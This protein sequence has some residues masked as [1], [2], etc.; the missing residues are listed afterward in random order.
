MTQSPAALETEPLEKGRGL[1]WAVLVAVLAAYGCLQLSGLGSPLFWQDEGETAMFGQR[2]L[3]F[4]YP[5]VHS[6]GNVVYGIG[7]PLAEGVDAD[8]DAYLGSFWGQYYF[9]A[10]GVSMGEGAVDPYTRTA[11][12]RLPFVFSGLLGLFLLWWSVQPGFAGRKGAGLESAI[13]FG[14][15]LC[16]SISLMLHIREVRYYGP[17]LALLAGGV[18]LHL[19]NGL[20]G[21]RIMPIRLAC[22]LVL[23]LVLFNFFFPAALALAAWWALESILLTTKN[24]SSIRSRLQSLWPLACVL[25]FF[26][27]IAFGL[28]QAFGMDKTSE[29]LSTRWGFGIAGYLGNLGHLFY[30]LIRYEW[31]VPCLLIEGGLV[32]LKRSGPV[33]M[34]AEFQRPLDTRAALYRLCVIY[35]FVGAVNP[36]FFERYFTPLGPLL[37]LVLLLDFEAFRRGLVAVESERKRASMRGW[38]WVIAGITFVGLI[39]VRSPELT[40]RVFEMRDPVRGPIDFAVAHIQSRYPDTSAL[41][42]ATNYEAEPLMFYLGSRVVGRFDGEATE[43][44]G[45]EA[46]IQPDLVIPRASQPRRLQEVRQYLFQAPFER[47]G[48]PVVDAPYNHIPE[49]YAGRVLPSVHSFKTQRPEEA[50]GPPLAIY[51]RKKVELK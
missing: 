45:A 47:Y 15:L 4:G 16:L 51:E 50:S 24:S 32:W 31:L 29:T 10:L 13:G 38:A 44:Q 19:R 27:G 1:R 5:K 17:A 25:V 3:E 36:I 49:L 20:V 39:W 26:L 35:I 46:E 22:A 21:N 28:I 30:F 40:G 12:V 33:R 18:A 48:L 41:T 8:R 37:G 6:E 34:G 7:V 42:I 23:L 43:P 14:I 2:V 11:W 9:A